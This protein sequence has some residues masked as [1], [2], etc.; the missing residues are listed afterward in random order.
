MTIFF[1]F[2]RSLFLFSFIMALFSLG[3]MYLLPLK[4]ITPMLPVLVFFFLITGLIVFYFFS[5]AVTKRFSM[6]T[7]YFMIVTTLKIM[8][9]L[10]IIVIYAILR[11]NDAVTFII[12]FF[13]L[14]LCYTV[15]EVIWMLKLRN[16]VV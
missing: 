10:C 6:F 16:P 8:L 7:N 14:Y 4:F 1:R 11:R 3:A 12:T 15:F 13:L 9:Y 5:K 2:M